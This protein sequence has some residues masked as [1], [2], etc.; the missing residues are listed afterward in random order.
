M[1]VSEAK[2]NFLK[3]Y[4]PIIDTQ[5]LPYDYNS[6]MHYYPYEFAIDQSIPTVRAIKEGVTIGQRIG[7]SQLDIL[8]VQKLYGCPQRKLVVRQPG[9]RFYPSNSL[10]RVC[11]SEKLGGKEV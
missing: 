7:M 11:G 5:G 8:R 4:P 9:K 6:I 10:K 2:S 3:L 1:F